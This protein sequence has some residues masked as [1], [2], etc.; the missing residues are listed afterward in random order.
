M[1]ANEHTNHPKATTA[2][3][4]EATVLEPERRQEGRLPLAIKV[5]YPQRNAFIFEYTRNISRGGMFIA[6]Q[7][8]FPPGTKFSFMLE[9]PHEPQPLDI[10]G[11]VRWRV[12]QE[13]VENTHKPIDNLEVGM[14]IAFKFQDEETRQSFEKHVKEMM[15]AEFGEEIAAKLLDE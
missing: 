7:S 3:G 8:P 6:T 5:R 12:T 1:S 11:E 10:E 15:C 14:G 13:D 9:I 2:F 4:G